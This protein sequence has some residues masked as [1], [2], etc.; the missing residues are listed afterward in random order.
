MASLCNYVPSSAA[1]WT[2][3]QLYQVKG[4]ILCI[5]IIFYPIPIPAYIDAAGGANIFP[6]IICGFQ[7]YIMRERLPALIL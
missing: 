4:Y 2:C 1:W 6:Y 5:S 3:Y 7:S